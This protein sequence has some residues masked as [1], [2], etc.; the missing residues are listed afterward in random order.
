MHGLK[1]VLFRQMDRHA[2]RQTGGKTNR[3][4]DRQRDEQI[5]W[6]SRPIV[7]YNQIQMP[8]INTCIDMNQK[9][10]LKFQCLYNCWNSKTIEKYPKFIFFWP[11]E[12]GGLLLLYSDWFLSRIVAA[13]SEGVVAWVI[14]APMVVEATIAITVIAG[15]LLSGNLTWNKDKILK[16]TT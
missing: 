2:D 9:V 11:D 12:L 16:T 5:N 10:L 14:T 13:E 3:H 15:S 4:Q 7:E 8:K 1:L 6:D